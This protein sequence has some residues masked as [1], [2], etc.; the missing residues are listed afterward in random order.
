MDAPPAPTFQAQLVSR[1]TGELATFYTYHATPLW[2]HADGSLDPAAL[3]LVQLVETADEDGLDPAAL[4]AS[5]LAQTVAQAQS[6]PTP[7][8][9][10]D[11][12]VALSRTFAAYLTALRQPSDATMQYEAAQLRPRATGTFQTL[13]EAAKAPVLAEYI[14]NMRWM[15][16]LYAPLRR[17]L[18]TQP[19]IAP[20]ARQLAITNL[21]RIRA[22]PA[23]P[24]G[25]HLIVDAANA[26]L[27]MY[28]GDRAVDSMRVIVGRPDKQTP[29]YAGYVRY[30][31]QNPYWKVPDDL[32]QSLVA[33]N[34]AS[35]GTA[36]L[37]RQGYEV[38]SGDN[39]DGDVVDPH[40]V[41]W[42]AVHRGDVHVRV[43]QLPGP[44]NSMGKVKYEFPN[45]YGIYLHDTPEKNL[46]TKDIRQISNGCIRL[47][48]AKRL[49]LWL[50]QGNMPALTSAPEQKVDLPTPIPIYVT[51][52]TAHAEGD[53]VAVSADPYNRDAKALASLASRD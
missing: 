41:N 8:A 50:M 43:R 42:A 47:E 1:S 21:E 26:T 48:D 34:A 25:R 30:A 38:V 49:G 14:H 24:N 45:V 17:A 22:I 6:N 33:R 51:Y 13:T 5:E 35:L 39:F 46:L 4:H 52:L 2:V 16:P 53:R 36:Y 20:L 12:E 11:A 37:K 28:E 10:A 31:I 3:E 19:A 27:W 29:A 23:Q 32:V 9:S 40:T 18:M 7:A 44:I 15:H